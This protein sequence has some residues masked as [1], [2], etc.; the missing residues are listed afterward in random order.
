MT[1]AIAGWGLQPLP[2]ACGLAA[3]PSIPR[4]HLTTYPVSTPSLHRAIL[5]PSYPTS[6][7]AGPQSANPRANPVISSVGHVAVSDWVNCQPPRNFTEQPSRNFILFFF[8]FFSFPSP[9]PASYQYLL[10]TPAGGEREG[11]GGAGCSEADGEGR[12][13]GAASASAPRGAP[14][15]RFSRGGGGGARATR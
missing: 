8:F 1:S 10:W 6:P 12:D 7:R 2:L 13:G 11:G 9:P 4:P 5:P 3:A 14:G 15:L